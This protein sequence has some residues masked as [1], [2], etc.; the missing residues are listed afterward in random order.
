ME[1]FRL[2]KIV[3]QRLFREELMT[4]TPQPELQVLTIHQRRLSRGVV[5]RLSPV[6]DCASSGSPLVWPSPEVGAPIHEGRPEEQGARCRQGSSGFRVEECET[7]GCYLKTVDL[8]KDGLAVPVVEDV[9]TVEL[10]VW[11][12][13]RGLRRC[14]GIFG[15][16]RWE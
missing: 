8:R 7:C 6:P 2:R 9:A 16:L 15:A 4:A 10:D 1:S 13:E 14:S 12:E 5:Y 3:R 11:A